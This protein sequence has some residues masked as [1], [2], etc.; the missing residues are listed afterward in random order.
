MPLDCF[1]R[2]RNDGTNYVTCKGKKDKKV[3]KKDKKVVKKTGTKALDVLTNPDILRKIKSFN[4]SVTSEELIAKIKDYVKK[5]KG[6]RP[7]HI[8]KFARHIMKVAKLNNGK[9]YPRSAY[10]IHNPNW[11]EEQARQKKAWDIRRKERT[12]H[13]TAEAKR[14]GGRPLAKWEMQSIIGHHPEYSQEWVSFKLNESMK[15]ANHIGGSARTKL[16]K[17]YQAKLDAL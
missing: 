8:V 11:K 2:T 3:V 15:F 12:K 1:T 17:Y 5:A 13:F 6:K 4:S 16:Y 10:D 14:I 9:P 7:S